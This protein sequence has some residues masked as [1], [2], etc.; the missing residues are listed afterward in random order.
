MTLLIVYAV[1]AVGVSFLCSLLEA[2]ILSL[3]RSYVESMATRGS[4]AG[5]RLKVMKESI[6]RPLAAILTLNTVAHTVGAAG[7]GAQAAVVFGSAAVGIASAVMTLLV[8]VFSE[9]IPKTLGAVHAKTLAPFTAYATQAL[10]VICLPIVIPLEW[11]NKLIGRPGEGESI[12]RAELLATIRLGGSS[13]AL[14]EREFRVAT[15][16][17]AMVAVKLGDV[18]TPRTVVFAL[19]AGATV[20][21]VMAEHHPLRFARVPVYEQSIDKVTGYVTR[22]AITNA[23][24]AGLSDQT[25]AS[26]AEPITVLPVAGTVS[27]ALEEMIRNHQHIALI[28]NEYGGTVGIVTLEDLIETLLG[29]EIVDETDVVTDM[30][31]LAKKR[32]GV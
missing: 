17:M 4:D 12:S 14:A 22:F 8:L 25:I 30:R 13:G 11:L 21:R 19:D 1:I 28:V 10:I 31:V 32:R 20:E 15:N 6:D 2:G 9:I 26:M 16:L 18:M 29:A 23:V 5:R 7:V 27:D 24:H 3:P